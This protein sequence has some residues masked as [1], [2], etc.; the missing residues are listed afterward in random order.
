[1]K[2]QTTKTRKLTLLLIISLMFAL[3]CSFI[4]IANTCKEQAHATTKAPANSVPVYRMYNFLS[5]EHLFTTDINEVN[6]LKKKSIR[7]QNLKGEFGDYGNQTAHWEYEGV[8]WYAPASGTPV[9]RLY[10]AALGKLGRTS[11]YY[12]K[13]MSEIKKLC[14]KKWGWKNEGIAFFSG[15]ET[16]IFTAYSEALGSTH[17]YTSDYSEWKKLDLGWD[18]EGDKNGGKFAG[19]D[20]SKKYTGTNKYYKKYTGDIEVQGFF[21]AI[22]VADKAER[23]HDW[24][25]LADETSDLTS[26][27][28]LNNPE[29]AWAQRKEGTKV[30]AACKCGYETKREGVFGSITL[31]WHHFDK[32]HSWS[33]QQYTF[34]Q[35]NKDGTTILGKAIK[36]C[37]ICGTRVYDA[38]NSKW[39]LNIQKKRYHNDKIFLC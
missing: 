9:Y 2:T 27:L 32:K 29:K 1:M 4:F 10:N 13:N 11:H 37:K 17:L 16:P 15:G 39:I 35:V 30:F 36:T 24:I 22:A 34:G 14:T 12:T 25:T 6:N 31:M 38:E 7:Y 21:K 23:Q 18:I 5:S 19:Y 28:S 8:N 33:P 20:K 26:T 3:V